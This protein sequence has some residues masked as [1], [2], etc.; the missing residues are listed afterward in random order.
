MNT[1]TG[2]VHQVKGAK[3]AIKRE[4]R[5]WSRRRRIEAVRKLRRARVT[6]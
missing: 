4:E 6:L 2:V 1:S 5:T 3:K